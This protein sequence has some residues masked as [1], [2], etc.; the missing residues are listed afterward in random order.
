MFIYN[1]VPA[2]GAEA[3]IQILKPLAKRNPYVALALMRK[4]GLHRKTNKAIRR[5]DQAKLANIVLLRNSDLDAL[6]STANL[7]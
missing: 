6:T 1:D 4:A 3:M 5:L 2:A 7:R